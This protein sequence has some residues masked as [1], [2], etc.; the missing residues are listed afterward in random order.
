LVAS[1]ELV[2][3]AKTAGYDTI[4]IDLEHSSLSISDAS[5][6]CSASLL[7]GITPFVRVPYQCGNGYVQQVLDGGAM[8]IVFPHVSTVGTRHAIINVPKGQ[9]AKMEKR[10]RGMQSL[11]RS[12]SRK[13]SGP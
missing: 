12:S 7:A 1:N 2:I 6:L 11:L 4:F 9:L 8:G 13:A 5:A 3:L 10:K